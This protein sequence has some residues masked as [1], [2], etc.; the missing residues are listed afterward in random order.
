MGMV[1]EFEQAARHGDFLATQPYFMPDEVPARHCSPALDPVST[2]TGVRHRLT[3][4]QNAPWS[5]PKLPPP[6]RELPPPPRDLQPPALRE[7]PKAPKKRGRSK[8]A[9]ITPQQ[10]LPQDGPVFVDDAS[11]KMDKLSVLGHLVRVKGDGWGAGKSSYGAIV[12]DADELTFTVNSIDDWVETQVLREHCKILTS[13][14][15][16]AQVIM[17]GQQELARS[18]RVRLAVQDPARDCD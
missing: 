6:A 2:P 17:E 16:V 3:G 14:R 9:P 18:K 15:E 8:Q 5:A 1:D 4:K 7:V 10:Q 11:V 12:T 13:H